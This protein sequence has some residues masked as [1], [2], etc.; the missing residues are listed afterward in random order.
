MLPL[1]SSA[2][3]KM[4][5]KRFDPVFGVFMKSDGFSF[6]EGAFSFG[7][8]HIH[9]ISRSYVG[10]K[11]HLSLMMAHTFSL[12]GDSLDQEIGDDLIFHFSRHG[13]KIREK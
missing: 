10:D 7:N 13:G 4:T 3:S 8:P 9:H 5:A 6:H 1:A 11:H 2:G 12:R